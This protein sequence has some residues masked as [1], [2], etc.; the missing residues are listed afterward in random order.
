VE[1]GREQVEKEIE[2][3]GYK[4]K[5]VLT[6]E[7]IERVADKFSFS[8][9]EDMYA[10]VGY[11][12]ITAAQIVTRLTDDIRKKQDEEQESQTLT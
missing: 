12:G 6:S 8:T 4:I 5:E 1:K 2:K 11:N 10:A 3:K 9:E 7:N